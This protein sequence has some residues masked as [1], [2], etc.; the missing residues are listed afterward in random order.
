MKALTALF[1]AAFVIA[2]VACGASPTAPA[3]LNLSGNWIGTGSDAQGDVTFKWT[4]T[5]A[6]GTVAGTAVMD[7]ATPNDGSCGSCHKQKTGSVTGTISG[8]LLTLRLD[9]P[10][11]GTDITPL[12]GLTLAATLSDVTAGRIAGNYTGTTTCEGT[13]TD[14]K[15]TVGR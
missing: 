3:P 5:Q 12:C 14:G 15:L 6:G 1:A 7:S 10:K 4:L 11:G 9:F 2:L 13:I 8:T